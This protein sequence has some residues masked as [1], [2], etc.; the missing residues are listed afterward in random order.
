MESLLSNF[1]MPL[2][3]S[4]QNEVHAW[5]SKSSMG[6]QWAMIADPDPL[7]PG[8]FSNGSNTLQ[9]A[10]EMKTIAEQISGRDCLTDKSRPAAIG[11]TI[12]ALC[13]GRGPSAVDIGETSCQALT[14]DWLLLG[15]RPLYLLTMSV[16]I[17]AV[18][19]TRVSRSFRSANSRLTVKV[20]GVIPSADESS[21]N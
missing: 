12:P 8:A 5:S 19:S 20:S 1:C 13:S 7:D 9:T 16:S 3:L 15:S 17:F 10:V 6:R 18:E 2:K 11:A 14:S 4:R 21:Q